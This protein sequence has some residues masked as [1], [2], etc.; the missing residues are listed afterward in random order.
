MC[1]V[2]TWETGGESPLELPAPSSELSAPDSELPAPRSQLRVRAGKSPNLRGRLGPPHQTLVVAWPQPLNVGWRRAG[3]SV[4]GQVGPDGAHLTG[5]SFPSEP[6]ELRGH[7]R[8]W[9]AYNYPAHPCH[10]G[11]Q[12]EVLR[13]E[14]NYLLMMV[15]TI[16]N[17]KFDA[18]IQARWATFG[19]GH[20]LT[21]PRI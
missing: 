15:T 16:F 10:S 12:T 9:C 17:Q 21:A 11:Y 19:A 14:T 2:A 13:R 5:G 18:V 20:N 4:S 1:A 8:S 6:G 3:L 7:N